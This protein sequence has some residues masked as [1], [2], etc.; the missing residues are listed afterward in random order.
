MQLCAYLVV[1]VTLVGQGLTFG[2]LLRRL[3]LRANAA[4]EAQVRHDARLAALAAALAAVNDM[5]TSHQ[6]PVSVADSLRSSIRR[7]ADRARARISM[8]E[9]SEGV[10]TFSPEL[11]TM[12][13]AQRA[14]IDAQ[15]EELVRWRDSGRLPDE[16]LRR[17]QLELDLEERALPGR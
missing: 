7:R 4:E 6:V 11:Q 15:R 10:V 12:I 9:E 16:S 2:P 3:G 17:L 5:Q 8:I 13:T 14:V 1:L